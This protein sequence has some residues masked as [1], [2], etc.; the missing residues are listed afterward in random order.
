M[1]DGLADASVRLLD[2]D[3]SEVRFQDALTE[4][5]AGDGTIYLVSGY[6][7][8]QGYREIRE[9]IVAFLERSRDNELVAVVSPASDQFSARIA[10]DLWSL[11]EH[12]QVR[13]YKHPRGLHAKLYIRDGPE[14]TCILGSAN[15]TQVAFKYNV[16]LSVE[17]S[18]ERIDHPDLEPFLEWTHELVEASTPLRRRDLLPPV[19]IGGS[20]VNWSNKAKHLPARN[21]AL[22][23]IPVVLL[24]LVFT[25]VFSTVINF[26]V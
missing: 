26:F 13:L 10:Q 19:Q 25:G 1:T 9:E 15:I 17:I 24:I 11:D 7:T 22:R 20:V 21:V 12:D 18:R 14:P 16:E 23:A 8:Y 5:F 6:F 4:L 2:S 3:R